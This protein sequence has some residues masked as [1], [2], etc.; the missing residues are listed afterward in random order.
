MKKVFI[1]IVFIL[2][3]TSIF[4]RTDGNQRIIDPIKVT[5][6]F[7]GHDD[8][9]YNF[10]F[11]NEEGDEETIIFEVIS[12]KLL[13]IYNLNDN[14][15]IDQEFEITY[16]YETSDDEIGIPVLYSIKKID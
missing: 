6:T 8:Y 9:G 13:E 11:I 15:F 3:V 4:A 14:K 16:N 10:L 7:L 2:F 5:A 12:E 1:K